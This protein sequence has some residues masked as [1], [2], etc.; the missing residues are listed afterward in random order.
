MHVPSTL[1]CLWPAPYHALKMMH[2]NTLER[3][4][5]YIMGHISN[6]Y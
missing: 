2:L 4:S 6:F 5:P 1:E 3:H